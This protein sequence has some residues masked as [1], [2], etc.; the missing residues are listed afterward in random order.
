MPMGAGFYSGG[1]IYGLP[2]FGKGFVWSESPEQ[3]DVSVVG[4]LTLPIWK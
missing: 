4:I 1:G 3:K 2:I